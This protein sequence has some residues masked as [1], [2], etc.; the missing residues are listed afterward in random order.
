VLD[1]VLAPHQRQDRFS[2]GG[3]NVR[4]N[5]TLAL[6]IAL[7]VHE[8]CTNAAKYG[9][10]S[11]DDG[12]VGISWEVTEENGARWLT[13]RWEE[14]QGPPVQMPLKRGFGSRLIEDN[15]SYSIG[16]SSVIKF[17]SSGVVCVIRAPLDGRV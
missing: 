1:S 9:A 6:S 7:A 5:P 3:P 10:L 17:A 16:G 8:L 15:F 2:I 13:L 14:R 11:N 4:L 12:I